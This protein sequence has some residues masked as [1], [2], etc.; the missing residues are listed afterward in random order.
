MNF[1][2]FASACD[3]DDGPYRLL[4]FVQIAGVPV[5]TAG[6]P[7]ALVAGLVAFDVVTMQGADAVA[8]NAAA[9]Q[10]EAPGRTSPVS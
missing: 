1:T 9:T 7:V 8:L 6:V 2:W 5:V 3:T 4:T 10:S